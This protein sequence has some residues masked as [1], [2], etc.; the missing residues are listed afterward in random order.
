MADS[1][2]EDTRRRMNSEAD[3]INHEITVRPLCIVRLRSNVH[4]VS[5]GTATHMRTRHTVATAG[6]ERSYE[7]V[8]HG[9][10][11]LPLHAIK[12]IELGALMDAA[13]LL[14]RC[15]VLLSCTAH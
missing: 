13:R 6:T 14:H 3:Q 4:N 15:V 5:F 12:N 8:A 2:H 7:Q 1:G 9:W 11:F 10:Y